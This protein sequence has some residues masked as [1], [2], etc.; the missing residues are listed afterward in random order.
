MPETYQLVAI[1]IIMNADKD[2]R[3]IERLLK[4]SINTAGLVFFISEIP[5]DLPL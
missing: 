4:D 2:T 3:S 1:G 5:S